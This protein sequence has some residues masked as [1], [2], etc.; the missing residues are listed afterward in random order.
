MPGSNAK[1]SPSKTANTFYKI[2]EFIFNMVFELSF[3]RITE[4]SA[5]T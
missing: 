2:R 4:C 3:K 1:R 5:N